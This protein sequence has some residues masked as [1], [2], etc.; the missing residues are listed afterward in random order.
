[1]TNC[2]VCRLN[3]TLL[4]IMQLVN[5]ASEFQNEIMDSFTFKATQLL[6]TL[7]VPD[8]KFMYLSQHATIIFISSIE[9]VDFPIRD[10]VKCE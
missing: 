9:L 7:Y 10:T 3:I 5:P 4:D 1:M 8:Y 2:C 6:C